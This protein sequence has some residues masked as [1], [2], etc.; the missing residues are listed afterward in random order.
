MENPGDHWNTPA[1]YVDSVRWVLETIDLDPC[2]NAGSVVNARRNVMLPED[3][4]AIKWSGRVFVNPPYSDVLPW[5]KKLIASPSVSGAI[6]LAHADVSTKWFQR[7]RTAMV[8][9]LHDQ[10]IRFC[11]ADGSEGNARP[12]LGNITA[13]W[14]SDPG[15]FIAGFKGHGALFAPVII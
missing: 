8:V 10:R 3:G 2:S 9:C 7:T 13:Y 6:L 14:G 1:W 11:D 5:I 12:N 4:L 15:R